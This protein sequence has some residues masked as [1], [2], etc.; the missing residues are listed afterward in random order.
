VH[1]SEGCVLCFFGYG[2]GVRHDKSADYETENFAEEFGLQS[3]ISADM[4]GGDEKK[5]NIP[6]RHSWA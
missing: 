2:Q 1:A 6:H 5:R 4:E 3:D